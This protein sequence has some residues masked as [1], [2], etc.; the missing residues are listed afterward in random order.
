[1]LDE[2]TVHLDEATAG[3][4][5]AG[6]EALRGSATVLL[7]THDLDLAARADRQVRLDRGRTVPGVPAVAERV[8]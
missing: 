2:P 4:V 8:R 1:V 6:I 3:Q 5:A 7:L